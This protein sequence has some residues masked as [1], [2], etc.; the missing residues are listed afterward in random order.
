M[1]Y[2]VGPER[3]E[4]NDTLL[5]LLSANTMATDGHTPPNYLRQSFKTASRL[6]KSIDAPTQG[7]IVPY[8]EGTDVIADLCAAVEVEKQFDLLRRAQQFSVNVFPSVLLRLQTQTALH[9]VQEGTGI[10]HLNSR[11][12]DAEFGLSE[13]A[14]SPMEMHNV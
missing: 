11:F 14:V 1:T 5:N 10:L 9:E 6:F 7:V 2:P 8:G 3:H 12:Y 13:S 4:R